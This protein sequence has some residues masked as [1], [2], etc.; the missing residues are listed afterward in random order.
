V[1]A[2]AQNGDARAK[3][4]VAQYERLQTAR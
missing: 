4:A 3:A 2:Q 1:Y